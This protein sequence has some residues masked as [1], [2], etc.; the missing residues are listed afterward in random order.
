MT[1]DM[2]GAIFMIAHFTVEPDFE[3]R[4]HFLG[5]RLIYCFEGVQY[6]TMQ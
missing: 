1:Q 6:P 4:A 3:F 2:D 5:F